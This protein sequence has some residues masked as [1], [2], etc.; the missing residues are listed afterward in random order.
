MATLGREIIMEDDMKPGSAPMEP[1]DLRKLN[2][3]S[4]YRVDR[5]KA[6]LWAH[7]DIKFLVYDDT[8]LQQNGYDSDDEEGMVEF[9]MMISGGSDPVSE[10]ESGN[11]RERE[12]EDWDEEVIRGGPTSSAIP[13]DTDGIHED[14]EGTY[15]EPED[16][17][18]CLSVP[19]FPRSFKP[20]KFRLVQS[21]KMV[22]DPDEFKPGG[23]YVCSHY[24]AVSYCWPVPQQDEHGKSIMTPGSYQVRDLDGAVRSSR[25]LD[26]ILDRAVE[27]AVSCG[28]RMIWIDQEC[29]PQPKED[30]PQ[31]HKD[32]QELGVQ[33][34]DVV[35]NRAC[36]TAGLLSASI[37]SQ[38]QMDAV[39][40]LRSFAV[41]DSGSGVTWD[42]VGEAP[43]V[44][45]ISHLL[46]HAL[47]FLEIVSAD[48]WYTRAWVAQEALSAGEVLVLLL[49]LGAGISY[50]CLLELGEPEELPLIAEL[51]PRDGSQPSTIGISMTGFQHLVRVAKCLFY[52]VY[53]RVGDAMH[54]RAWSIIEKAEELHPTAPQPK[55]LSERMF[56]PGGNN[57][58]PRQT[59]DAAG[60]LTLLRTRGCRDVQDRIAIVA[61]MCNFENRLNT[62]MLARHCKS[63]RLALVALT[64]LNG[65][66]SLL[67]PEAYALKTHEGGWRFSKRARDGPSSNC[68]KI[69]D[70]VLTGDNRTLAKKRNWYGMALATQPGAA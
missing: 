16:C 1:S 4:A 37:T 9:A 5:Q 58:R 2:E 24:V 44:T 36:L 12:N 18:F 27:F 6:E 40:T 31:E 69:A 65:D 14:R 25:A 68:T 63:L 54:P 15:E 41:T 32:E 3:L 45:D 35:Y 29:L 67:V 70:L 64:V 7:R 56:I 53:N 51:P 11:L 47:D 57:Y 13:D 50:E 62:N 34:M 61:N 52:T 39:A 48:R 10:D 30:S 33:A 43:L 60:A 8:N 23:P 38:D 28:I 19:E 22:S 49:P 59:A 26:N 20:R 66:Y 17:S 21:N 55:I 46:Y 42:G